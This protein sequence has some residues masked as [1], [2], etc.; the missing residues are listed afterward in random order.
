[1][2]KPVAVFNPAY[3]SYHA[4]EALKETLRMMSAD[5]IPGSCVRIPVIGAG[6]EADEIANVPRFSSAI[7]AALREIA[8]HVARLRA[9]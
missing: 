3:K 7:G 4:D 2:H 1:M 5:L 6:I 8:N 9:G